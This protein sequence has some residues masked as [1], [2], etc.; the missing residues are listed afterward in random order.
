VLFRSG[1]R[2]TGFVLGV[3]AADTD[4][5]AAE[6]QGLSL[7]PDPATRYIG[8]HLQLRLRNN[9]G[10][11]VDAD[12]REFQ[13]NT[14]GFTC[15]AALTVGHYATLALFM[16]MLVAAMTA[17]AVSGRTFSW[18]FSGT[19]VSINISSST[20]QPVWTG[21]TDAILRTKKVSELIG[22]SP[23]TTPAV[24]VTHTA[25]Q[26]V[27]DCPGTTWEFSGMILLTQPIARRP[28]S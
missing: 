9:P 27:H 28:T 5:L 13:Y 1:G 19:V 2:E 20:W 14:S 7:A 24:A 25:V 17:V 26:S 23:E 16:D 10:Y 6:D 11:V 3:G 21:T 22:F 18:G 15:T 12:N 4:L 8:K